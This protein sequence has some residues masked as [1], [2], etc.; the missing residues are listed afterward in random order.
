[1][2][3]QKIVVSSGGYWNVANTWSPSGV[4]VDGDYVY[5][6]GNIVRLAS[7]TANVL[8]VS[9]QPGTG[10]VQGGHVLIEGTSTTSPPVIAW[11]KCSETNSLRN[12]VTNTAAYPGVVRIGVGFSGTITAPAITSSIGSPQTDTILNSGGDLVINSDLYMNDSSNSAVGVVLNHSGGT[13]TIN[14]NVTSTSV[15]NGTIRNTIYMT[16]GTVTINGNVSAGTSAS[17]ARRTIYI[18][19]GTLTINNAL[20]GTI[21]GVTS[22]SIGAIYTTA[23]NTVMNINSNI[24]ASG[25]S[26]TIYTSGACNMTIV[27]NVTGNINAPAIVTNNVSSTIRVTG[28]ITNVGGTM[29]IVGS[30]YI[31]LNSST[32]PSPTNWNFQKSLN[33]ANITYQVQG[34]IPTGNL[35]AF[36]VRAG[37]NTGSFVGTM[38]VPANTNVRFN[39]AVDVPPIKGTLKVEDADFWNVL[40]TGII[41]ANSMGLRL[42]TVSTVSTL[43]NQLTSYNG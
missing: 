41:T 26:P 12:T 22:T 39:T 21:T 13:T 19:G 31:F 16:G 2:G 23:T 3:V 29:A 43:G 14:G 5:L 11:L 30:K 9:S 4:P 35:N 20:S 36:D 24:T 8:F 7:I 28:V 17:L 15:I 40:T 33:G 25:L 10:A 38:K 42:K 18:A 27:G 37:G 32:A 6:N 34:T 1:M